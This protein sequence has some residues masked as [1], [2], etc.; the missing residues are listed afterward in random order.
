MD[1]VT[2][3]NFGLSYIKDDRKRLKAIKSFDD[4]IEAHFKITRG[5]IFEK[6]RP[7][8]YN[9]SLGI[10]LTEILMEDTHIFFYKNRFKI[11]Q[12]PSKGTRDGYRIVFGIMKNNSGS[13]LYIPALV[14]RA[15]EEGETIMVNSKKLSLTSK[16]LRKIVKERLS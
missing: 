8:R 13:F 6:E 15:K 14:F 11:T 7:D 10:F 1:G 3:R 5:K 12:P 9:G 2:C 4:D 16:N